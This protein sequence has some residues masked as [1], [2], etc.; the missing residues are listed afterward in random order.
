MHSFGLKPQVCSQLSA[1]VVDPVQPLGLFL[2][3]VL[4]W[5]ESVHLFCVRR[6]FLSGAFAPATENDCV[7]NRY[8]VLMAFDQGSHYPAEG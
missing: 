2:V 4:Q 3:S 6:K 1:F 8:H 5:Q 7:R